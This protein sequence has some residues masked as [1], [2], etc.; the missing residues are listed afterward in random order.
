MSTEL[1]NHKHSSAEPEH[2]REPAPRAAPVP[3]SMWIIL[4][5]AV[6][7][8]AVY[9]LVDH[10]PHVLAALPYLGIVAVVAMHLF[11]HGGHGGQGSSG[12][13]GPHGDHDGRNES[14]AAGGPASRQK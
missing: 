13:T 12:G 8:I 2:P 9:L 1:P 5:L 10:W 11:G 14:G 3:V 4:A 7:G 6:A